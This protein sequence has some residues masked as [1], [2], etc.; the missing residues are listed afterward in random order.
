MKNMTITVD[1]AT[2]EW[3]RRLAAER[4]LSMSRCV[5]EIL[6]EKMQRDSH[7]EIAMRQYMSLT[8]RPLSA[9]GQKYPTREEIYDRSRFR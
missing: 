7:Y 2:A 4:G 5:G 3:V 9:P 6:S 1:E 8:P